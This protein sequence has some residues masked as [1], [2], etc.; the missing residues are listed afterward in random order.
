MLLERHLTIKWIIISKHS[1]HRNKKIE[2]KNT[3]KN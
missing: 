2:M 1:F 3:E